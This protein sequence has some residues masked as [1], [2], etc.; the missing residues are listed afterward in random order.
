MYLDSMLI[1]RLESDSIIDNSCRTYTYYFNY[2]KPF[3][4][5]KRKDMEHTI[6]T[7]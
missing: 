1:S 3:Y 2:K 6:K 5:G 7:N 4:I